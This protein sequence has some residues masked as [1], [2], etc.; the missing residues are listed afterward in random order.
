MPDDQ[1]CSG[2]KDRQE[3]GRVKEFVNGSHK[4]G[5]IL[6]YAEKDVDRR[7]RKTK[8]QA[9]KRS[10]TSDEGKKYRRDHGERTGR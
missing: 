6:Y 8:S 5:R 7:V 4:K 2:E 3:M 10:G 1:G 9:Q